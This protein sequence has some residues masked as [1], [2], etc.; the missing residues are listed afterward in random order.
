MCLY[1]QEQNTLNQEPHR[2]IATVS[3]SVIA[4]VGMFAFFFA[5][6][7]ESVTRLPIELRVIAALVGTAVCSVAGGYW[8]GQQK[9]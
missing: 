6:D 1:N 3:G 7:M 8:L 5:N 2:K 4:A 9:F